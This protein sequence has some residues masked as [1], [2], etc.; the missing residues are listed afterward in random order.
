M[1]R[2]IILISAVL[3]G[4]LAC[5]E[6]NLE[7][8]IPSKLEEPKVSLKSYEYNYKDRELLEISS[9]LLKEEDYSEGSPTARMISSQDNSERI[10]DLELSYLGL[11]QEKDSL[12]VAVHNIQTGNAVILLRIKEPTRFLV[13]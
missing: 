9:L 3:I 10:R 1:K 11:G 2:E 7:D 4:L 6:N 5:N 13:M 12:I 8:T